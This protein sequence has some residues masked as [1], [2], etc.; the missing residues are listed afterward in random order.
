[1]PN[2]QLSDDVWSVIKAHL[3]NYQGSEIEE[4]SEKQNLRPINL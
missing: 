3:M 2:I 4:K 1:M